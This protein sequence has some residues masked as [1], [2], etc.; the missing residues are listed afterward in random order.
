MT[1]PCEVDQLVDQTIAAIQKES[2]Q[3]RPMTTGEEVAI[4]LAVHYVVE[5]LKEKE[6]SGL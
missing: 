3:D 1:E 4:N 5:R 2:W 6:P